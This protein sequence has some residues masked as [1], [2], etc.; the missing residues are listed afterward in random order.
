MIQP[1]KQI[2]NIYAY[3]RVSSE[4]QVTDG[5]SLKEN[6]SSFCAI[7]VQQTCG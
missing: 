2:N 3:V 1:R 7:K 6:H 4:Q 5:S